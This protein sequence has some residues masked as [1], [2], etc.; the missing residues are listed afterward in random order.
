V[1]RY[2]LFCAPLLFTVTPLGSAMVLGTHVVTGM[3]EYFT[4]RPRLNLALFLLYFTL[5][6]LSY[7]LG[8]WWG[9]IKGIFFGPVNPRIVRRTSYKEIG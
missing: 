8:V 1:S 7:Q 6:Q 9:C 5:D 3:G 4:K 2:Y